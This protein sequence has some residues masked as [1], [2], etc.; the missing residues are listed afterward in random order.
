L[1]DADID[2]IPGAGAGEDGFEVLLV[3]DDEDVLNAAAE[4]DDRVR[5]I[6]NRNATTRSLAM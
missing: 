4:E 3:G 2:V 6:L 5:T 1:D